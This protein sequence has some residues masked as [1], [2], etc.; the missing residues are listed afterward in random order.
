VSGAFRIRASRADDVPRLLEIWRRAVDAT[1]DFL[2]SED[3]AAIDRIVAEDY[4]PS[5][6]L[7]VTVNSSDSPVAFL[8][9]SGRVVES[10]FVD[11]SVYGQGVGRLLID[12]FAA[13]GE[14]ELRVDVNEQNLGARAFYERLGF[15]LVGRSPLDGEGRPYP[16]LH[17]VR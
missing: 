1:H 14:G 3:R 4:L 10:L 9:G 11:P 7:L 6:E 17:L 15:R 16:L 13:L 5:A 2:T 8:G 12:H